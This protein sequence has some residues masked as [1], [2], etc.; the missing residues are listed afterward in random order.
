MV[1]INQSYWGQVIRS[2]HECNDQREVDSREHTYQGFSEPNP[3]YCP[4][5]YQ[6]LRHQPLKHQKQ[7]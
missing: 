5:D 3:T 1:E 4:E 7:S 6:D 2:E